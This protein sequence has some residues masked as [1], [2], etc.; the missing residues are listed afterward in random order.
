MED[1]DDYEG[2]SFSNG[3]NSD[4]QLYLNEQKLPRT[5]EINVL[6]HRKG[7]QGRYPIASRMAREI[8]AILISTVAS[9]SAFSIGG[10]VLDAYRSSL[11]LNT[12]E[13]LICV[14][15]WVFQKDSTQDNMNQLCNQ[16]AGMSADLDDDVVC[17]GNND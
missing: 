15:D 3:E 9:E 11:N 5:T 10:K 14:R 17:S 16:V 2:T 7:L 12:A 4:F 6:D 8:L 1:L 13:V